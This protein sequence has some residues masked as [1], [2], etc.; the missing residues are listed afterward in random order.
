M[1]LFT[2]AHSA[3]SNPVKLRDMFRSWSSCCALLLASGLLACARPSPDTRSTPSEP[4]AVESL[5]ADLRDAR[6]R[7]DVTLASGL[8]RTPDD[9]SLAWWITAQ[10][11][12]R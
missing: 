9:T 5:Y 1:C 12:L 3:E 11:A 6:D 7:I 8:N 2:R 10:N 4:A